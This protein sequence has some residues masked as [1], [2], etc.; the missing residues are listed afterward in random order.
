M[1]WIWQRLAILAVVL[2]P[3]MTGVAL[4][5]TDDLDAMNWRVSE[6][7]GSGKYAEAIPLAEKSLEITRRQKGENDLQTVNSI[8]WLAVLYKMQGRYAEAE[9]LYNTRGPKS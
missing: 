1:R 2:A 4:A 3:S 8:G 9:P 7:F 5:Q 6:L